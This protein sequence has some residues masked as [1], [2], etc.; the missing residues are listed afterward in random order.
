LEISHCA[1]TFSVLKAQDSSAEWRVGGADDPIPLLL[2][3]ELA[4]KFHAI[5]ADILW[6]HRTGSAKLYRER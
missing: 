5:S 2:H 4:A 1:T 3:V 6:A